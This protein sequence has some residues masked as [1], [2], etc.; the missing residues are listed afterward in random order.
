MAAPFVVSGHFLR[1]EEHTLVRSNFLTIFASSLVLVDSFCFS[2][3][4]RCLQ[5]FTA[6]LNQACGGG[7]KTWYVSTMN[8]QL[9]SVQLCIACRA[10]APLHVRLGQGIPR[11][12]W[13]TDI[14]PAQPATEVAELPVPS[15]VPVVQML[16]ATWDIDLRTFRSSQ[17]PC[18]EAPSRGWRLKLSCFSVEGGV[19]SVT[20]P[21]SLLK[22]SFGAGFNHSNDG[23]VEVCS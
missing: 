10:V 13:A 3:N 14:S 5:A 8:L 22:L 17:R 9:A 16:S 19:N 2:G 11:S 6:A 12:M 18:A 4:D 1:F 15:R 20:W 7:G 23:L 21:V